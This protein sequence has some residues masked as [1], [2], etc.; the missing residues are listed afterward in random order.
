MAGSIRVARRAGI[1]TASSATA[2]KISG[3]V[4]KTRRV[5]CL[6]PEEKAFEHP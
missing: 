3:M 4:T 2:L 5:P 6:Y 1:H